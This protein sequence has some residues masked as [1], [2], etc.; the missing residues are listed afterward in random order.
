VGGVEAVAMSECTLLGWLTLIVLFLTGGVIAWY[1]VET[2]RLRRE[3]QLQTELQNRPFLSLKKSG[4]VFFLTNAGKGLARNVRLADVIFDD[5][6]QFREA[7][8]ITHVAP[9]KDEGLA[10]KVYGGLPSQGVPLGHV[11]TIP[12]LADYC[13][14]TLARQPSD[15]VVAVTIDYESMVGHRYRTTLKIRNGV[16]EIVDDMRVRTKGRT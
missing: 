13:G 3:A 4:E 16:A 14:R 15:T 8:V 2:A 10:W 1:T 5:T 9:E 12:D 7:P 11:S 6:F